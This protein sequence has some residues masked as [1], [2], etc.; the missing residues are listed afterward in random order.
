[1]D[2]RHSPAWLAASARPWGDAAHARP[3]T[4][5][6]THRRRPQG[7]NFQ[8][9]TPTCPTA[10][11][12]RLMSP[13][14][15]S[16]PPRQETPGTSPANTVQADAWRAPGERQGPAGV[17]ASMYWFP[18]SCRTSPQHGSGRSGAVVVPRHQPAAGW[19]GGAL[20]ALRETESMAFLLIKANVPPDAAKG[21][22]AGSAWSKGG[23]KKPEAIP[24]APNNYARQP[25][26]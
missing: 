20:R 18:R 24:T 8:S 12:A 19:A 13:R 6:T 3:L 21:W 7:A 1:M 5:E 25:A 16:G 17:A 22:A 4:C 15:M 9:W 26:G 14:R 2:R 11:R 10:H 23:R